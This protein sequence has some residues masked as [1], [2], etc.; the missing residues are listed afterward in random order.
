[1]QHDRRRV[2]RDGAHQKRR[3]RLVTGADQH[4]RIHRLGAD[5]FLG[6]IAIRLRNIMLVGLKNTSPSETVG[7]SSGRPPAAM[8]PRLTASTS[9]GKCRWQLLKPLADWAMPTIGRDSISADNPIDLA[10]ERRR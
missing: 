6:V 5:H 8:T 4:H 10:N 3:H 1:D 9:S 2:G 7:K